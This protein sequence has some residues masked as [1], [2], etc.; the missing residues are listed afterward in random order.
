VASGQN[1]GGI[2]IIVPFEPSQNDVPANFMLPQLNRGEAISAMVVSEDNLALGTSQ[3]R[4]LQY[5]MAGFGTGSHGRLAPGNTGSYTAKE[6][7]PGEGSH[8]RSPSSVKNMTPSEKQP[9]EFPPFVPPSPALSIDASVLKSGN[10]GARNGINDRVKSIFSAY[11]LLSEPTLTPLSTASFGPLME[12]PMLPP[13][14]RKVDKDF[15]A[16]SITSTD[17][18]YLQTIPTS[19]LKVDLL[20]DHSPIN[21]GRH[22]HDSG[23]TQKTLPNANKTIYNK[24]IAS[25]V[26][27][28]PKRHPGGDRS[29][30]SDGP[31]SISHYWLFRLAV[32]DLILHISSPNSSKMR[33]GPKTCQ[34][35][36]G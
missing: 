32:L 30:R 11:T 29:K 35:D 2:Q 31:V 5:K 21:N 18:D 12:N 15:T 6:F 24:K 7:I 10:R 1:E 23:R 17:G 8:T 3:C 26:Y 25:L 14:K 33:T 28:Q 16:K 9:L 4:V 13:S 34:H 27:Q 20:D 22:N 36:I 19:S